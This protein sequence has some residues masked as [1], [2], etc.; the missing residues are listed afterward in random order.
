VGAEL[1]LGRRPPKPKSQPVVVVVPVTGVSRLSAKAVSVALSISNS[2]EVVSV[3]PADPD[4]RA[5]ERERKF[6]EDWERWGP[7][8]PLHILRVE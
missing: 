2:V 7:G 6:K 4:S 1:G 8:V 5:D 3:V